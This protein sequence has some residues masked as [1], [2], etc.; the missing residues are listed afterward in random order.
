MLCTAAAIVIDNRNSGEYNGATTRD[1]LLFDEADQLPSA[2]A[3]QV[4][5]EIPANIFGQFGIGVGTAE[6][7]ARDQ[8][9]RSK[10]PQIVVG[11]LEKISGRFEL[12]QSTNAHFSY[13]PALCP[14]FPLIALF[15]FPDPLLKPIK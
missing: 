4:D 8:R 13:G 12:E 3:M 6:Q 10:S 7:A 9:I 14:E 1:Y 5:M 2:A 15:K 11:F